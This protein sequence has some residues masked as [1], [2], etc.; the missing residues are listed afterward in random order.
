MTNNS[1]YVTYSIRGK[2]AEKTGKLAGSS[3]PAG[4]ARAL[5][6]SLSPLPGRAVASLISVASIDLI[7]AILT[8][9][10]M[11][12]VKTISAIKVRKN[13]GHLLEEVYYQGAQYVIERAGRPMAAV[14]PL[15]QLGKWQ[16]QKATATESRREIE[17]QEAANKRA[18]RE[19][20]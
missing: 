2:K 8:S 7:I 11:K 18:A 10:R 5:Q 1:L 17:T 12:R 14:V 4:V 13:L 6:T 20:T 16:R 19:K 3:K 9:Q 15:L